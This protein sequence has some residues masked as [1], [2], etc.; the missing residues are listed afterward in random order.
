MKNMNIICN[1]YE[2]KELIKFMR[3]C[4]EK[5]QLE[6]A[7]VLGKN[8]GWTAKLEGGITNISLS[9]FL[10]LAKINDIEIIMRSKDSKH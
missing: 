2:T 7:K 1:K 5:T 3:D 10:T 8:R 4:S 9:D 6:F